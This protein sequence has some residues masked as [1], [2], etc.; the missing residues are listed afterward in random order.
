VRITIKDV[1][2]MAGVSKST[3]SRVLNRYPNS[4]IN[5]STRLKIERVAKELNFTAH[6]SAKAL[7]GQRTHLIGIIIHDV[8]SRFTGRLVSEV[9]N[10]AEQKGYRVILC[11][12]R[13][14]IKREMMEIISLY[15]IGVEG[16]IVEHTGSTES[17]HWMLDAQC[18]FVLLDRCPTLPSID[19][20]TIDDVEGGRLATQALIDA[21]FKRIAHI[22]ATKQMLQAQDRYEGFCLAL[23]SSGVRFRSNWVVQA[24]RYWDYVSGKDCADKLLDMSERPDAFFCFND[25]LALGVYQ[26]L[27][28]RGLKV[29]KDVAVV[30]YDDLEF[31]AWTSVPLASVRLDLARVGFEAASLLLKKIEKGHEGLEKIMLKIPPELVCRESLGMK[32]K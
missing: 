31:D 20:V 12:T 5:D 19:Y 14:D 9:E 29:G 32:W 28:E 18:P 23:K 11:N 16:F 25:Y 26:S 6:V 30:G 4:G 8:S 1:A 22:T 10:V 17:L 27:T 7:A 15:Q 24:E 2:S 3:V 21:G 13:D